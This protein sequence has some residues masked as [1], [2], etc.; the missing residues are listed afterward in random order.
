MYVTSV[1]TLCNGLI[2]NFSKLLK[3]DLIHV[4]TLLYMMSRDD[5]P[6][7]CRRWLLWITEYGVV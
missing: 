6:Y 2:R 3:C 1:H 4:M 7:I 5:I